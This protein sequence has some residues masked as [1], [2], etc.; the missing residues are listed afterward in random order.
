M[1]ASLTLQ[2]VDDDV[3][4]SAFLD[5]IGGCKDNELWHTAHVLTSNLFTERDGDLMNVVC[6][7]L[8]ERA[9]TLL[10]TSP[11]LYSDEVKGEHK[12]RAEEVNALPCIIS[13]LQ[14]LIH[15]GTD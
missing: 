11:E 13:M 6:G 14:Q 3:N 5:N 1:F 7:D 10:T 9:R 4:F 2:Q 15:E 8:T 12:W